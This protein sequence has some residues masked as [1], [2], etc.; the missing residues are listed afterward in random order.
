MS[1]HSKPHESLHVRVAEEFARNYRSFLQRRKQ[2]Y[3]NQAAESKLG[4]IY[5]EE[6]EPVK[7][8]PHPA[9]RVGF[10]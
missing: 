8:H 9:D 10:N 3:Q 7:Q 2:R 5:E 1:D 4:E 6:L